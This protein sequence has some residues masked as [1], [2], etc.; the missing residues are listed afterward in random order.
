MGSG[1]HQLQ[2]LDFQPTDDRFALCQQKLLARREDI[3]SCRRRSGLQVSRG[4]I[5]EHLVLQ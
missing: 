5:F 4:Y 2:P 3:A 1:Q